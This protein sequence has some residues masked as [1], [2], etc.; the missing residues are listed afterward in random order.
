MS[1]KNEIDALL[2]RFLQGQLNREESEN[3]KAWITGEEDHERYFQEFCRVHVHLQW[4]VR[5][6]AIKSDLPMF[7]QRLTRRRRIRWYSGVAAGI[8]LM[9]GVGLGLRQ[10]VPAWMPD[11]EYAESVVHPGEAQ[12]ML[13]LSSGMMVPI[14]SSG[15]RLTEF[16]GTAIEVHTDGSMS[17]KA[18]SRERDGK[19]EGM[20]HLVVPRKGEFRLTLADGTKVWLNSESEL[21]YPFKFAG[22]E[23]VVHLKGEAYFEVAPNKVCPFIVKANGADIKVYGTQFNV[24]TRHDGIVETVLVEGTV[25]MK[26]RGKEQVLKPNQKAE[27]CVGDGEIR[28]ETVDVLPYIAWRDGNFVFKNESLESIM[29]KLSLWYD[30]EVFYKREAVKDV[31]LSG[32]MERYRDVNELLRFFEK[33]SDLRFSVKENTVF[34]E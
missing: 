32:I 8:V 29:E 2:V 33:S 18:S 25:G 23:R 15:K 14:D 30:L 31:R 34:V 17:Y 1:D 6:N 22:K 13:Y 26:G 24:N 19:N 28:V 4:M 12:A 27:C 16:D 9:L 7:R 10:V 20:N 21:S 11:K 5:E 3:V